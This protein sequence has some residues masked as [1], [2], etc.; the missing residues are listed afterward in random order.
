MPRI[1]PRRLFQITPKQDDRKPKQNLSFHQ[2]RIR[3]AQKITHQR[4]IQR[5]PNPQ[6][7]RRLGEEHVLLAER[8]QLRIS[9]QHPR[10]H[11]LV[12]DPDHE[13]WEDGEDD[14]VKR[15]RPGLIGDL[16]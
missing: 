2:A 16:P 15:D 13:R 3:G 4:M 7:K 5:V 12:K 1:Q 9:I 11:E 14:V 8:I 10:R 6:P